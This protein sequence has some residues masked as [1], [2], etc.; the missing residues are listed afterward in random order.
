VS[1]VP[2]EAV[3]AAAAAGDQAAWRELVHRYA[4]T[5]WFVTRSFRLSESD[6]EDVSQT[7]WLL[8]AVHLKTIKEPAAIGGWL[9]TAARR[10]C[11]RLLRRRGRELPTDPLGPAAET[12]DAEAEQGEN[13]VLRAEQ[14]ELV[15]AAFAQ[16]PEPCRR[17][18]GLLMRDPPPPYE[19]ISSELG[20]PRG[21]I[22]PTRR[23]CLE[24]LRKVIQL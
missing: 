14:R 5:V 4:R 15:R 23:R 12:E 1:D 19:V 7:T 2:V 16:L 24:R 18:L 21:S 17:L 9:A 3:V 6:A 22:G 13:V 11:I 8:L 20:V 10:E